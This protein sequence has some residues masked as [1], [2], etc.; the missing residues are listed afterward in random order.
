MSPQFNF[1]TNDYYSKYISLLMQIFYMI[2]SFLDERKK[3]KNW[4]YKSTLIYSPFDFDLI[5]SNL[6]LMYTHNYRLFRIVKLV[7][8]IYVF[9]S[10]FYLYNAGHAQYVFNRFPQKVVLFRRF[11]WHFW[12]LYWNFFCLL[13]WVGEKKKK[14]LDKKNHWGLNLLN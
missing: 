1:S 14:D 10:F 7:Q 4:M 9:F 12:E 6:C 11:L 3:S 8:E 13:F 5:C 2:T